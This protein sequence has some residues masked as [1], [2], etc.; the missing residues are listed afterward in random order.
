M[1]TAAESGNPGAV[2]RALLIWGLCCGLAGVS[3]VIYSAA[4]LSAGAGA[5]LMPLDDVYIHFQYAHQIAAGQPYVYNPGLPPTSGATSFLYPYLLALGDWLGWRGLALSWWALG[6]GA[7]ALAGSAWLTYRSAQRAAPEWLAVLAAVI[8]ALTGPIT[9][10]YFSGMETGLVALFV[11]LMLERFLADDARGAA[12]GAALLALIRPEG[13]ALAL[14]TIAALAL[15]HWRA[16]KGQ[17]APYLWL[18][19][20]LAALA[21]QPLINLI[22]TGSAVASGSAAKSIFGMIPQDWMIIIARVAANFARMWAEFATGY[23]PREGGYLPLGLIIAAIGLIPYVIRQRRLLVG[24]LVAAWL[25]AGTGAIATLDTAF[26]HFKRYQLPLMALFV[27]LGAWGMA[28]LLAQATRIRLPQRVI[29]PVVG[30]ALLI[31]TLAGG[32][33]FLSHYA[34]NV[35]YVAAQP[36]LMAEWLRAN[37]PAAATVAVHDVGMMRYHGGR[38]T[39]DIVG[40]TTP[41]AAES[42]RHGPGAVAELIERARPAY[43]AAYGHGHGFGLGQLEDT[44][45]YA[46]TLAHYS[47]AADA[48]F[49]RFNV[50]LA[51]TMQGIY[52]PDWAAANRGHDVVALPRLTP[53]LDGLTLVDQVDVADLVSER[54]HDYLWRDAVGGG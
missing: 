32:A 14:L 50:A 41:G 24:L 17:R 8:F 6:I 7:L 20:P 2:R 19:L 44:D 38:T 26:W 16:P 11:L 15:R 53:Y 34:L 28:W 30:A 43:I 54:A 21:I 48:R 42:W 25:V 13:G 9:W 12:I 27:P 52:R 18:S 46:E 36:L 40:L 1:A 22:A 51:A 33:Q 49:D 39:L 31:V 23:S 4:G 10:H 37:T 35:G 47:V 29:G 3:L 45:L 5:P